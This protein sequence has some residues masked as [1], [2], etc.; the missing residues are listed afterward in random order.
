[1]NTT[2]EATLDGGARGTWSSARSTGERRHRVGKEREENGLATDRR[3]LSLV[4]AE[5]SGEWGEND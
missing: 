4:R 5:I 3:R 2:L 1:M